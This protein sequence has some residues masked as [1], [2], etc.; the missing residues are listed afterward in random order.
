MITL[1]NL[2]YF[3]PMQK[4]QNIV[5]TLKSFQNVADTSSDSGT[6]F[7]FIKPTHF[8]SQVKRP[9]DYHFDSLV[10]LKEKE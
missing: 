9:K 7:T 3:H 8:L 6:F 5:K 4:Y 1:K 10:F 2:I